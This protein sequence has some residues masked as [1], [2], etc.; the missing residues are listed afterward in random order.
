MAH[1]KK[2]SN[3]TMVDFRPIAKAFIKEAIRVYDA[4]KDALDE[5]GEQF[6][7]LVA[8]ARSEMKKDKPS[9]PVK[10]QKAKP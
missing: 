1:A 10:R 6:E 7:D 5:A 4:A 9:K 3:D 2:R 8:E